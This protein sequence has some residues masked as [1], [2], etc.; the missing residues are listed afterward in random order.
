MKV[1]PNMVA[2][3]VVASLT[4]VLA[5]ES[6]PRGTPEQGEAVE[7]VRLD[8]AEQAE[9]KQA[10]APPAP[11]EGELPPSQRL[12]KA[13]AESEP[14]GPMPP[15]LAIQRATMEAA[16][17]EGETPCIKAYNSVVI[18]MRTMRELMQRGRESEPDRAQ[19]IALCDQLPE[20]MQTCLQVGYA[21]KNQLACQS[22]RD[23]L[24]PEQRQ[25][26]EAILAFPGAK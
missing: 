4:M 16:Q 1:R 15:L 12:E 17:A 7:D 25:K 14:V 6:K 5:C 18:M 21:H 10:E 24:A 23:Q 13:L 20:P 9:A 2:A 8:K 11:E 26:L 19:F 22:R 3:L